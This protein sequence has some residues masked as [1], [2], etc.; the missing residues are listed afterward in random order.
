MFGRWVRERSFF[1]FGEEPLCI[2]FV[3]ESPRR[4]SEELREATRCRRTVWFVAN[5]RLAIRTEELGCAD[6]TTHYKFKHLGCADDLFMDEGAESL[7]EVC[8]KYRKKWC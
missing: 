4:M 6:Q 3:V 1:F 2:Y 5:L 8:L 7:D